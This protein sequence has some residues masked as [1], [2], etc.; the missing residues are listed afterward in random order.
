MR[1][2]LD[3]AP[4]WR[5]TIGFDHVADLV[6]NALRQS[7]EDKYPPCNM[8]RSNAD[9]FRISLAVTGSS[10]PPIEQQAA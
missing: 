8:G 1:T 7:N 3:L 10:A 2:T 9:Q 4:L 6:D 5:S